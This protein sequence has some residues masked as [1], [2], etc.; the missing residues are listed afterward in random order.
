MKKQKN[1]PLTF[2]FL[3]FLFSSYAQKPPSFYPYQ[4]FHIGITGQA[5]F[6]QKPTYIALIG[7][8][9][10]PMP[11][12]TYGWEVG[13]ELSY[14]FAKYFGVSVGINYGTAFSYN[15]DVYLSSFWDAQF[16]WQEIN[17]YEPSLS[18][19]SVKEI[20]FPFKLEIHYP[21]RK[22]LFIMADVGI[23]I[24][25]VF[26]RLAYGKDG[27]GVYEKGSDIA[28]SYDSATNTYYC[29]P[30]YNDY[31]VRNVGKISCNLLLG[32]GLSY[33]LPY[34]DLLRFTTGVNVSF[35][36]IIE[37]YYK[38]Y[39]TESYGTFS[40]KNDFI[41]TQLSYIHTFKFLKAKKYVKKQDWT[42]SSKKERRKKILEVLKVW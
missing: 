1:I 18:A 25:G 34:G 40:V 7:A 14:H 30:Y 17:R 2:L 3:L 24:K 12:W 29:E 33:Q 32:V 38:Y 15:R 26:Q 19:M 11:R 39:L 27:I 37:G 21:L 35:N 41:Y 5:E 42:F 36:N 13:V 31:G 4:G 9:P 8:E 6:I 16:G 20:L 22:N 10:V 28:V 23:K